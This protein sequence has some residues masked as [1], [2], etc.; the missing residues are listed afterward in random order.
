MTIPLLYEDIRFKR[1]LVDT[2]TITVN[3]T[4]TP[5]QTITVQVIDLITKNP[6]TNAQLTSG[7][8]AAITDA[9][10]TATITLDTIGTIH[11]SA[12]G[13]LAKTVTPT[14]T[15]I[16]VSLIPIWLI[17]AGAAGVVAI[18]VGVALSG[19]KK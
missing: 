18:V 13:Y 16:Q 9:A 17:G 6:I 19:G 12:N 14:S 4:G 2:Q 5:P 8:N 11:I 3:P 15:T 1:N 7:T 10:G